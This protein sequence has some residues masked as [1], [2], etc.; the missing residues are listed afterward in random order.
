MVRN[1]FHI[2]DQQ[3]CV[4][5]LRC[6]RPPRVWSR[7]PQSSPSRLQ[8]FPLSPFEKLAARAMANELFLINFL[9]LSLELLL[10]GWLLLKKGHTSLRDAAGIYCVFFAGSVWVLARRR[11]LSPAHKISP[12]IEICSWCIF[13]ALTIVCRTYLLW[14]ETLAH[15]LCSALRL[16]CL[17]PIRRTRC[18]RSK[19]SRQHFLFD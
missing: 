14:I 6:A 4:D 9:A 1:R 19:P 17:L 12:I 16:Y 10:Y 13:A 5:R 18:S 2:V 11:H 7:S 8:L 15:R 3:G